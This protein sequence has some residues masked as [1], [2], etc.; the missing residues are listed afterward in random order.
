MHYKVLGIIRE[1][2]LHEN[3]VENLSVDLLA[4]EVILTLS[5]PDGSYPD[6]EL[7]L[8]F[9]GVHEVTAT[10]VG[11]GDAYQNQVLRID[12]NPHEGLYQAKITVGYEKNIHWLLRLVF[13]DIEYK[14]SR[15]NA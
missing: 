2:M 4:G 10:D 12:C 5:Q 13:T 15:L 6:P 11:C 3:L 9:M 8:T 14:R 1:T 7:L